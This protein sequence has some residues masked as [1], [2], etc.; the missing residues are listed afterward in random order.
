MASNFGRRR[1][2]TTPVRLWALGVA[3]VI[4]NRM[5]AF[6][7]ANGHSALPHR[8]ASAS[9]RISYHIRGIVFDF[10]GVH[11]FAMSARSPVHIF[12]ASWYE[13]S[14]RPPPG[15]LRT[16]GPDEG[17]YIHTVRTRLHIFALQV[18]SSRTF[19]GVGC[20]ARNFRKQTRPPSP[21]VSGKNDTTRGLA[22]L[23]GG[24]GTS[25]YTRR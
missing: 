6:F 24:S 16:A 10:G 25:E 20:A 22:C 2:V 1:R 7:N 3:T 18:G 4:P 11:I 5:C 12:Q 23:S 15:Y 19:I 9:G 14:R 8:S 17:I 21:P 13:F